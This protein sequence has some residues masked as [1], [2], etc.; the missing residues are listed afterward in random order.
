M[1]M[2]AIHCHSFTQFVYWWIC[3]IIDDILTLVNTKIKIGQ[4]DRTALEYI[5]LPCTRKHIHHIVLSATAFNEDPGRQRKAKAFK[6][7]GEHIGNVWPPLY[8][9]TH[10]KGKG[11]SKSFE[12]WIASVILRWREPLAPLK[13]VKDLIKSLD[14]VN[15]SETLSSLRIRRARWCRLGPLLCQH[16]IDLKPPEVEVIG[17]SCGWVWESMRTHLF[18]CTH[19]HPHTHSCPHANPG[20]G[21][22]GTRERTQTCSHTNTHTQIGTQYVHNLRLT[23]RH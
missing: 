14:F 18:R 4:V 22:Q 7:K 13:L 21:A 9:W 12:V 15:N 3:V 16:G 20:A 19:T 11:K 6:P 17:K 5:V 1:T 10:L 2:S 23:H 8:C